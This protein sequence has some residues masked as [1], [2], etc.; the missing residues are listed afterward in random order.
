MSEPT[1]RLRTERLDLVPLAE[2]DADEMSVVLADPILYAFTG[3]EP[4]D[5]RS[6]RE[7]FARLAVGHSAD[8]TEEWHNWI[9]RMTGDGVAVGTV[10]ATIHA[11]PRSAEIAWVIGVPWQGHGYASEAAQ[12]LVG[13]LVRLGVPTIVAHVHPDHAASAA[14]AARAGLVATDQ[15]HDGERL[16][17][18]GPP[19]RG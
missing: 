6:L 9:A 2:T 4:P 15:I 8:G 3:G 12:A 17:R 1:A 5:P 14:V 10:Q 18:L 16:W 11:G 19:S 7:R 13:W